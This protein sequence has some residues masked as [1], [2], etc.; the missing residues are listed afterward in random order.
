MN[1]DSTNQISK[2]APSRKT[3][4]KE[5]TGISKTTSNAKSTTEKKPARMYSDYTKSDLMFILNTRGINASAGLS[6]EQVTSLVGERVTEEEVEKLHQFNNIPVE[7]KK[8]VEA[9]G[10]L[11]K[12]YDTVKKCVEIYMKSVAKQRIEYST[13]PNAKP[14]D[15]IYKILYYFDMMGFKIPMVELPLTEEQR[16]VVEHNS[17]VLVVNSGPGTGKTTTGVHKTNKLM[18]EGVVAVSYTNTTVKNFEERLIAVVDDITEIDW[19]ARKKIWLTTIDSL[20]HSVLPEGM[21]SS[22][23]KDFDKVISFASRDIQCGKYDDVF[24]GSD[25]SLKY[26]HLI[27]DEAQDIDDARFKVLIL[28]Y[29]KY[30]M[31]SF[32]IIGDPRQRLSTEVGGMFQ[33]M[34]GKARRR[35]RMNLED[36]FSNS[37]SASATSSIDSSHE[38]LGKGT[39]EYPILVNYSQCFRFKNPLHLKVCNI[40]SGMR[41]GI[42]AELVNAI[43]SELQIPLEDAPKIT[44]M[45]DPMQV[46]EAIFK[47]KKQGVPLSEICVVSPAVQKV[48][49]ATNQ[50]ND[51]KNALPAGLDGDR[52]ETS[53]EIGSNTVYMSSIQGVKGLEFDHVFFV[54]AENYPV[55]YSEVYTDKNDGMSMNFVVNT[56]ARV[57]LSYVTGKSLIAPQGVPE[58]LMVGGAPLEYRHVKDIQKR[59]IRTEEISWED[60]EKFRAHNLFKLFTE[61]LPNSFETSENNTDKQYEILSMLLAKLNGGNMISHLN[62][63]SDVRSYTPQEFRE[64]VAS[65]TAYDMILPKDKASPKERYC[66][67]IENK[68]D[69][70]LLQNPIDETDLEAHQAYKRLM[71][72]RRSN[73]TELSSISNIVMVL[74]DLI[75]KFVNEDD[76]IP[77]HFAIRTLIKATAIETKKLILVFTDNLYLGSYVKK[78]RPQK[79]ILCVSLN[80]G[81]ITKVND[82]PFQLFRYEYMIKALYSLTAHKQLMQRR[83]KFS[84]ADV[85]RNKPWVFVDTEFSPLP[86]GHDKSRTIYDIALINAFDI[87]ASTCSLVDPGQSN[88]RPH[89]DGISYLDIKGSPKI[90]QLRAHYWNAMDIGNVRPLIHYFKAP[91]DIAFFYEAHSHYDELK[92][93]GNTDAKAW[94]MN[95]KFDYGADFKDHYKPGEGGLSV[96][97][98]RIVGCDCST[99]EHIKTHTA[100]SDTLLLM[101]MIMTRD[102]G[103]GSPVQN[104]PEK[105]SDE[106]EED[107]TEEST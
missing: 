48:G 49:R 79:T 5:S 90:D 63:E 95:K 24:L 50:F 86:G 105:E 74:Y 17:G 12:N 78:A 52:I 72:G 82:A 71:T 70:I 45:T 42:H 19:K 26:S 30:K 1:T 55:P 107:S 64:L 87:Y 83:G 59:A 76:D 85:N 98:N 77:H 67:S 47:L 58:D 46:V 94:K 44:K 43:P 6:L 100:V 102:V 39:L 40:L 54:G 101:E 104:Y 65:G 27:V 38:I 97:Y 20:C 93:A 106:E 25:G 96:V 73:L 103:L 21:K 60:L 32:T 28:I 92:E 9:D 66:Y 8:K 57:S 81:I 36:V 61:V 51:I 88:F 53:N 22:K 13:P 69:F 68:A 16:K 14:V 10:W 56:R 31:K 29:E 33:E 84:I 23:D 62:S 18:A 7:F 89:F 37:E 35:E 75:S 4:V 41:P 80:R 91:Y 99:L 34:Y 11:K 15:R 3:A 2:K